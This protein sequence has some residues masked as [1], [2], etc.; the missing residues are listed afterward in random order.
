M[1]SHK[2]GTI[3]LLLCVF[4]L[5]NLSGLEGLPF[6]LWLM[7]EFGWLVFQMAVGEAA[8]IPC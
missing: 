6:C 4:S 2:R 7:E 8:K 1:E 5:W 3:P